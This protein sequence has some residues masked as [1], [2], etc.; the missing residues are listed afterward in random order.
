MFA[1]MA[2]TAAMGVVQA[3]EQAK[4]L[5]QNASIAESN[6]PY[7]RAQAAEKVRQLQ[8]GRYMT[9]GAQRGGYAGRGLAV[10]G[11]VFDI[12]SDTVAN[13]NRDSSFALLEGELAVRNQKRQADLSRYQARTGMRDAIVGGGLNFAAM[14]ARAS[15]PTFSPS[16]TGYTQNPFASSPTNYA[17]T[18]FYK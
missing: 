18:N 7:I 4:V 5:R 6:I 2:G 17:S 8:V 15:M 3:N 10:S 1:A 11:S 9:V 13:F 16:S 14:G 12:M